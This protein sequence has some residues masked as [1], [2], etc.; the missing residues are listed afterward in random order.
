MKIRNGF[1]SNSSSSS[2]IISDSYL[3]DAEKNS[4]VEYSEEDFVF[5]MKQMIKRW[6]KN[7]IKND[8]AKLRQ[9][10][11]Y[12]GEKLEKVLNEVVDYY[13]KR[14]SDSELNE[15]ITCVKIDTELLDDLAYFYPKNCLSENY[16]VLQG[17]D[18]L[19][20]YSV[21]NKFVRRFGIDDYNM[22]MG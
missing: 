11:N 17:A 3:Y 5:E 19:I 16:L 2:F 15:G 13:E 4:Y 6:K 7:R 12:Q 9:D 8:K 20:P 14:W 21:A 18:N 10:P 1:V 22:H